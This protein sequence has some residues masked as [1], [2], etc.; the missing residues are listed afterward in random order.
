VRGFRVDRPD[1]AD[2]IAGLFD[3]AKVEA[4]A[5]RRARQQ[6]AR[7]EFTCRPRAFGRRSW[8]RS[9]RTRTRHFKPFACRVYGPSTRAR[10]FP[11]RQ[12]VPHRNLN[13]CRVDWPGGYSYV[14]SGVA[15]P[16]RVVRTGFQDGRPTNPRCFPSTGGGRVEVGAFATLAGAIHAA[17]QEAL[18]GTEEDRRRALQL[19]PAVRGTSVEAQLAFALRFSDD[20]CVP[21]FCAYDGDS[22]GASQNRSVLKGRGR[23]AEF[24]SKGFHV[25]PLDITAVRAQVGREPTGTELLGACGVDKNYIQSRRFQRPRGEWITGGRTALEQATGA[26]RRPRRVVFGGGTVATTTLA[27]APAV[28]PPPPPGSAI[29]YGAH[30]CGSW[31]GRARYTGPY[32]A[33]AFGHFTGRG[34]VFSQDAAA[35]AAAYAIYTQHQLQGICP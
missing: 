17:R 10:G 32:T 24:G 15:L 33:G 4:R 25:V 22:W 20:V 29:W 30:P 27:P 34:G 19:A 28:P 26:P 1:R 11:K 3:P 6:R 13:A 12:F 18:R 21:F 14:P 2:G 9:G 7:R 5:Q 31:G 8:P 23:L 35:V 16:D